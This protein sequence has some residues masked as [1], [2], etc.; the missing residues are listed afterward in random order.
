MAG[1]FEQNR[2]QPW[3]NSLK[4]I[5]KNG[6]KNYQTFLQMEKGIEEISDFLEDYTNLKFALDVSA[7][8]AVTDI[9]GEII[10][11]NN[12]FCEISKYSR[13]E[14]IGKDHRII[15]SG[16]HDK[17][18]FRNMWSQILKG[19]VW[20]GEVKNKAKDGSYYW[21]KTTIV[22]LKD[23]NG[24]TIM[25][26]AIRT[27]ISEG[28]FAK[29]K[30]LSAL[31]NDY[32]QIVSSMNNLIFKVVKDQDHFVYT[33]NEGQLANKLG[34]GNGNMKNKKVH[35]IF[36][37][38]I[39]ENL[40]K[41]YH[42]AFL[43]RQVSYQ[44]PFQGRQLLTHITPIYEDGEIK[45]ILGCM[46]DITELHH[47]QQQI[48]YMAYHDILSSLPNRR[49]FSDDLNH[50]ISISQSQNERIALFY[51]DLD[52]FK[53]IND[54]FGHA[55]GD[56]LITKVS[57][58]LKKA[59][60]QKGQIYRF[61]GDEFIILLPQINNY[62]CATHYANQILSIFDQSIKLLNS[63]EIFTSCSIGISIF[64]DHGDDGETL[65][66]NADAA[67]Y[68]AK[69][70][71]RNTFKIYEKDMFQ[72][73]EKALSI[74]YH[75][76]NAIENDE[77]ELYFQPKLDLVSKEINGMEALLRWNNRELGKLSPEV[78][79]PTAEDT[80][81]IHK[82]DKWVLEKAC[83][84]NKEW[85]DS[86]F[87]KPVKI[88]VNISPLHFRLPNFHHV[89]KQVLDKTGL[90]PHLLEIEITENSFIDNAEEC[91]TCLNELRKMGVS[92]AID[93]FGKGYSSLNYL[94]KFPI[95]SLKID[96]TF[97]QE[98]AK[99][100]DDIAIVKAITYLAHELNL[101][102]VAEGIE[103]KEVIHILE[104]IGCDEIQGYYISK[105]LPKHEFEKV[106]S[107]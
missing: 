83:Q 18:F 28:K 17:Q 22:P 78:F 15:N 35:E 87:S 10:Y 75:L 43:G 1:M 101:K 105:P 63:L 36:P 60:C 6:Q 70:K 19:E 90:S 3:L 71:G 51:I 25:F 102:V 79:I 14:L 27:D 54:S 100:S 47:A 58:L 45:E 48:E 104:K 7:I 93:D 8:V 76:R 49:K 86:L 32:Q 55:V 39:T 99:N 96:R 42:Q 95:Q 26:I 24:E 97:I 5:F 46:N 92:V 81:F 106:F 62:D 77:F 37:K 80:G 66:K 11:V 74:E 61:A 72:S 89:I 103:T 13:E 50:L 4:E 33:L 59:L 94:R 23:I 84:Q 91:I 67:M 107:L 16:Y 38:E 12:K 85:N 69:S 9:N 30:L 21:V 44:Y 53:Q 56:Q 34:L 41:F 29:E 31:Q 65:L 68:R 88:S 40:N 20:E 64:P 98:V 52:R 57:L 2:V 82:L 73:H